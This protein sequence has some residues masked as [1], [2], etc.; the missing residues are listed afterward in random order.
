MKA[1]QHLI[2][3]A[4]ISI[5]SLICALLAFATIFALGAGP[6]AAA[7]DLGRVAPWLA[8]SGSSCVSAFGC[9]FIQQSDDGTDSYTA[10]R[11]GVITGYSVLTGS[12]FPGVNVVGLRI[13]RPQPG[14]S[15]LLAGRT[16]DWT[17]GPLAGVIAD[18]PTRISVNAGDQIGVGVEYDGDTAWLYATSSPTDTVL[19]VNT[20]PT[21]GATIAPGDTTTFAMSRVNVKARLESDADGDGY[22]DESQDSC[23]SDAAE[24]GACVDRAAPVITAFKSRYKRFRYRPGGAVISKRAHPGTTFSLNL[25]E[26]ARVR[27]TVE[28]GF[29]G[30]SVDGA[31]LPAT[32]RNARSRPCTRFVFVHAFERSLVTGPNAFAYAARY[33]SPNN[34]KTG[35]LRPGPYR[36]GA[37]ATDAAGNAGAAS[38][39]AFKIRS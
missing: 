14:D 21:P 25:S 34:G 18:I 30:R 28:K 8:V 39:A 24:H 29:R 20:A 19:R 35:T 31:C 2:N 1:P 6:A 13:F 4:P 7:V 3:R 27:F 33:L 5:R 9:T 23:P 15:W 36:I 22:G 38:L 11:N 37:V 16:T 10:P 26:P 12:G 17:I 32:R